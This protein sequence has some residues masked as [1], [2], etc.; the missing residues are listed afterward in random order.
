MNKMIVCGCWKAEGGACHRCAN[1]GNTRGIG[2]RL[3]LLGV[4]QPAD[5]DSMNPFHDVEMI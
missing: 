1:R 3:T 4:M 5:I 2:L